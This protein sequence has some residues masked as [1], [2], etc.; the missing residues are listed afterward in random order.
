MK[1]TLFTQILVFYLNSIVFFV[2]IDGDLFVSFAHTDLGD[3]PR[4]WPRNLKKPNIHSDG[5]LYTLVFF[6][7]ILKSSQE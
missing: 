1:N 2:H 4:G 3:R 7:L 5:G 6:D